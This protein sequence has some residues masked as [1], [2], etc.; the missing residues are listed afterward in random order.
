MTDTPD[1]VQDE[2]DGIMQERLEL[3]RRGRD[4]E[5]A[6]SF[7]CTYCDRG[8]FPRPDY[9]HHCRGKFRRA[10]FKGQFIFVIDE[11]G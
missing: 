2:I 4:G 7:K 9:P 10:N 5:I 3:K 1:S 6:G 11:E 8:G